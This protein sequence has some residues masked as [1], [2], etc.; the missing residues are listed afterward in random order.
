MAAPWVE[1][2]ET[3]IDEFIRDVEDAIMRD[4]KFLALVQ[5]RGNVTMNHSGLK[6]NWKVKF[7]RAQPK[8]YADMD[9]QNFPRRIRHKTATLPWRAYALG[10]AVS[11]FDQLMNRGAPA[12]VNVIADKVQVMTDDMQTFFGEQLYVDGEATGNEKGIHGLETMFGAGS[13]SLNQPI[14]LPDGSYAGITTDLGFYG[15]SWDLATSGPGSGATIWPSGHSLTTEYDFYSPLL[16]DYTNSFWDT[17]NNTWEETCTQAVRYAIIKARKNKSRQGQIDAVFLNEE[18]YRLWIE[19]QSQ[20]E[21]LVVNQGGGG[22]GRTLTSMGYG[23]TFNFEG[24]EI[25]WEFGT[26][27]NTGYGI[28]ADYIELASMQGRLFQPNGPYEHQVDKT[29]RYDI[30][31]FGNLRFD[32]PKFFFKLFNYS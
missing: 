29:I 11:K 19:R 14:A 10:E 27:V 31:F 12:I 13:T 1:I 5:S 3:T 32:S 26:P 4:Y 30:D 16:V 18:L 28:N 20:K 24:A 9:V 17:P 6:M 7:R 22:D 25:T 8:G 21:R 23:D 2:V 15:G